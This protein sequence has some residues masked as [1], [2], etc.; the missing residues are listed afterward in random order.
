MKAIDQIKKRNQVLL[1]RKET[2]EAL[3]EQEKDKHSPLQ[4]EI[5]SLQNQ[6]SDLRGKKGVLFAKIDNRFKEP[7]QGLNKSRQ[8]NFFKYCEVTYGYKKGQIIY[9]R[10]GRRYWFDTY[11]G[12][13]Q[14]DIPNDLDDIPEGRVHCRVF[15]LG[16]RGKKPRKN[17]NWS[18]FVEL[19]YFYPEDPT[20]NR[21]PIEDLWSADEYTTKGF[22][23]HCYNSY[24]YTSYTYDYKTEDRSFSVLNNLNNCPVKDYNNTGFNKKFA[25]EC[26][27][28]C[29]E[30]K[31]WLLEA[32]LQDV[33]AAKEAGWKPLF[34]PFEE[35][36][37]VRTMLPHEKLLHLHTKWRIP[38]AKEY[39]DLLLEKEAV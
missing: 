21:I 24:G 27:Q 14:S 33:V 6:I 4:E 25:E 15:F 10:L 23:Y 28:L 1:K 34:Q 22:Y 18:S 5:E 3:K 7:L 39:F 31:K 37:T 30:E 32:D 26:V 11:T 8:K 2:L 13:S 19:G 16:K 36:L 20:T 35:I 12:R 29:E 9:D 38:I 17:A